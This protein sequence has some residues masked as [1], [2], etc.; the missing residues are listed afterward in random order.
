MYSHAS[1]R[2]L[3]RINN[4]RA[5]PVLRLQ[6]KIECAVLMN[7]PS[8]APIDTIRHALNSLIQNSYAALRIYLHSTGDRCDLEGLVGEFP[9]V[10]VASGPRISDIIARIRREVRAP[11]LALLA[12]PLRFS[13][14][15]LS[16]I[17]S[18][19]QQV[20]GD[21]IV[22]PSVDLEGAGHYVRYEGNGNDHTFQKFA[23]ALWRNQRSK[24]QSLASVPV[25]CAVLTWSCLERDSAQCASVEEW[26]EKLCSSGVPAYWAQDTFVGSIESLNHRAIDSLNDSITDDTMIQ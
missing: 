8:E 3:E 15:W 6:Q 25:G 19:V 23:R 20:G 5:V 24:F 13:K 17:A 18:V 14:Q 1:Q 7:V 4:L 10:T 16:Q 22:A 2:A 26:L 21:L 9:Q 12:T 11:Y